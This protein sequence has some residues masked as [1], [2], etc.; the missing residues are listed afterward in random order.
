MSILNMQLLYIKF[1]IQ[2]NI[3][4]D[5]GDTENMKQQVYI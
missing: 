1:F 3:V 5:I 4:L 2:F